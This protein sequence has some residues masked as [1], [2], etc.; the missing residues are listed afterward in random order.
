MNAIRLWDTA[1]NQLL[2]QFDAHYF[3]VE[4]VVFTPDGR[5][6]ISAGYDGV[7]RLWNT[8]D[9]KECFLFAAH[10]SGISAL[11]FSASG[12][13]LATAGQDGSVRLWQS[14][15]GRPLR[16]FGEADTDP[17]LVTFS[18]EGLALSHL[19][20][21]PAMRLW[22]P[23]TGRELRRIPWPKGLAVTGPAAFTRD[24]RLLALAGEGAIT[25]LDP[26][27]GKVVRRI[28]AP[29]WV[30]DDGRARYLE[31]IQSLALSPSG[32]RLASVTA[33][34]GGRQRCGHIWDV[35]SGQELR[36]WDWPG[37]FESV[38]E[39]SPDGRTLAGSGFRTFQDRQ[40]N[41]SIIRAQDLLQVW[42]ATTGKEQAALELP[43]W[44]LVITLAFSADGKSLASGHFDGQIRLWEVATWKERCRFEGH[45][46]A[47]RALDFTPDGRV[48]ASASDDTTA[49][50]WDL[51]GAAQLA[52]PAKLSPAALEVLWIDLAGND[53][54]R[55]YRALRTLVAS[56]NQAVPF[57]QR[58]LRP[59]AAPDP[60]ALAKLIEG[61]DSKDYAAREK[62][63]HAL[64]ELAEL[65]APALR[66][67]ADSSSSAEVRG[68]AGRLLAR[69][70][71]TASLRHLRAVEVLE[72]LGRADAKRLLEAL[73]GGTP[74]ARLTR[75]AAA[76]LQRLNR[77]MAV[78]P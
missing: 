46:G 64:E 72:H 2:R 4:S 70:G 18:P 35:A 34:Q 14:A 68:R 8:A 23:L 54:A 65:A 12:L 50:L 9:G 7:L 3:R 55:A 27:T 13:E 17:G 69:L 31:E 67:A 28:T 15:T 56:P 63:H 33:K 20:K 29:D 66:R 58:R 22:D 51:W 26:A 37:Q 19:K 59:A 48:L 40:E 47:V 39:F 71:R 44:S 36:R 10:S 52:T 45:Q 74:A 11:K 41:T 73:A 76:A 77:R 49:L 38:L 32:K 30:E 61:L 6:L 53:A 43:Q 25:L 78:T 16:A 60:A 24:G 1:T 62:A 57:L 75:D 21:E 5:T 42:D